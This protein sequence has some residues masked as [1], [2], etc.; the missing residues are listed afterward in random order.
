[1]RVAE[2][3]DH[4]RAEDVRKRLRH[5]AHTSSVHIDAGVDVTLGV[6]YTDGWPGDLPPGTRPDYQSPW[7]TRL[8]I[9][10]AHV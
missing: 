10:I 5:G 2:D 7:R 9:R 1:M 3:S 4:I 8:S 6:C